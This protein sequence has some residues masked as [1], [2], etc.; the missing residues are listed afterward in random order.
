MS[1]Q[2]GIREEFLR[3]FVDTFDLPNKIEGEEKYDGTGDQVYVSVHRSVFKAPQTVGFLLDSEYLMVEAED[4]RA[5]LDFEFQLSAGQ[6]LIPI[7]YNTPLISVKL[8][9]R[10]NRRFADYTTIFAYSHEEKVE[11]VDII[12]THNTEPD[13]SIGFF[14]FMEDGRIELAY[15]QD[16]GFD[17]FFIMRELVDASVNVLSQFIQAMR[18]EQAPIDM[19]MYCDASGE[20][21]D[22]L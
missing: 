5:K 6:L 11:G 15:Q 9:G 1:E 8:R 13:S 14:R 17:N 21:I 7:D 4:E 19:V 10:E 3:T 18:L 12:W 20:F 2:I 22:D 16:V